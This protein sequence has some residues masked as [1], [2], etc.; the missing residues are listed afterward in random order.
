MDVHI[1]ELAEF[2]FVQNVNDAV[3]EMSFEDNAITNSKD[4]FYFCLDL[5]C[6]G[7][8]RL[9]GHNGNRVEIHSLSMENFELVRNKMRNAGIDVDLKIVSHEEPFESVLHT[10]KSVINL[11]ELIDAND[12]LSLDAYEFKVITD[13]IVYAIR[14]RL[15]HSV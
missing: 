2:I 15:V 9:F 8:V 12:S 5:F 11:P 7:L 1:D 13:T 14:F 3:V 6:K 10:S 4:L